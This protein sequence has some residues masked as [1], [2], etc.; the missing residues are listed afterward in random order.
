MKRC[1]IEIYRINHRIVNQIEFEVFEFSKSYL[2]YCRET[3][4]QHFVI[5]LLM[6]Y[7]QFVSASISLF[8]N[9][10]SIV[11]SSFYLSTLCFIVINNK[12]KTVA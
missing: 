12:L 7:L 6:C 11:T 5:V 3:L 4:K 8:D 1:Y 2:V 10:Y 9:G